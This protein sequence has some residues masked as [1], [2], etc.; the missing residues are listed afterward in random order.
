MR[1][2]ECESACVHTQYERLCEHICLG[3]CGCACVRVH[4]CIYK[5]PVWAAKRYHHLVPYLYPCSFVL[6]LMAVS[7]LRYRGKRYK[8][9]HHF[10]NDADMSSEVNTDTHALHCDTKSGM[11]FRTHKLLKAI[12]TLHIIDVA[13]LQVTHEL[14]RD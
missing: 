8:H 9:N 1:K 10:Q 7:V 6:F 11:N 3:G 13:Y 5:V 2:R 12:R 4:G 14:H